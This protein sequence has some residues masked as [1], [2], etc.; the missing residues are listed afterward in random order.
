MR[1][2][3][4]P[5]FG[6]VLGHG[7]MATG[8]VDAVRRIAGLEEGVLIALSNEGK[9]PAALRDELARAIRERRVLVFTD[10]CAGSCAFAAKMVCRGS[11]NAVVCG[12]NLPML[13]E[14]VFN[15]ELPLDQLIPHLIKQGR[16]AVTA[17]LPH[18]DSAVP[19]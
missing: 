5:A 7:A 12:V 13:L 9:G 1:R 6:V 8:L 2:T 15:R 17:H 16:A 14:F 11:G 3:V 10:M 19:G 18:A 4:P